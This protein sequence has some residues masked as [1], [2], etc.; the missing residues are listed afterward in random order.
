MPLPLN[1][2]F[3]GLPFTVAEELDPGAVNEQVQGAIGAPIRDLD[4]QCL[5]PP[6]QRRVI[7]NGPIQTLDPIPIG[8]NARPT[9][10][11][12]QR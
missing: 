10:H 1:A 2:M 5:L 6:T 7:R 11:A 4:C 8:K 3:P 9:N 12:W